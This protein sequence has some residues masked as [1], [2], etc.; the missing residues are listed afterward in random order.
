MGTQQEVRA[1]IDYIRTHPTPIFILAHLFGLEEYIKADLQL[2]NVYFE[3]SPP[4]LIS[5]KRLVKAIDYF[6]AQK[7][8]FGSD[9][10]YGKENLRVNL[11]RIHGLSISEEEKHCMLGSNV[12]K[13]LHLE[14]T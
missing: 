14:D 13:L 1:L 4:P 9:T 5:I 3:I 11:Q 12:Q 6:G 8:I 2:D 7:M 10:P